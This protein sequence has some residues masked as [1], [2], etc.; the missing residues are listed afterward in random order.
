MDHLY[1]TKEG[2]FF[3]VWYD[4]GRGLWY[5]FES[6]YRL[7]SYAAKWKPAAQERLRLRPAAWFKRSVNYGNISTA[8][9]SYV[10][11][12]DAAKKTRAELEKVLKLTKADYCGIIRAKRYQVKK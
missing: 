11:G 2:R 1:K 7:P 12:K 3:Q 5:G 9:F 10:K 6:A 8:D 4:R